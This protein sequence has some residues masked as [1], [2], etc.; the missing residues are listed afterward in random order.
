MLKRK[1]ENVETELEGLRSAEGKWL[2][3]KRRMAEQL[4]NETNLRREL[5]TKM[6]GE[7]SDALAENES[8]KKKSRK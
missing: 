8:V 4:S 3:E 6:K 2:E 5:E 1:F 7:L